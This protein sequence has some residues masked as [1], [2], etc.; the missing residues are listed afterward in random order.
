MKTLYILRHGKSSWEN[1]NTKDFDRPLLKEG[2]ERTLRIADFL[3][4]HKFQIQC[5]M[6]SNAVRAFSTAKIIAGE[7]SYPISKIKQVPDL[8]S[9]EADNYFNS[10]FSVDD[11]FNSLMII[12]HNPS[13]TNFANYF[14][15]EK[16][17]N[18]P[19]S[20]LIIIRFSCQKWNEIANSE[21]ELRHKIF[22]KDF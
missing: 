2:V 8:Y 5:I 21:R 1:L 10:V 12:G 9:S 7:T 17:D 15:D 4:K 6:S 16:I 18:L 14:L 3:N 13:L 19:T 20:G 11:N 22:P